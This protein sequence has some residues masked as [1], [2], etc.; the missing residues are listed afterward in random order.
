MIDEIKSR[1]RKA[2]TRW[3]C[4]HYKDRSALKRLAQLASIS[5]SLLQEPAKPEQNVD[6]LLEAVL[7]RGHERELL[8]AIWTRTR[9][10][11]AQRDELLVIAEGFGINDLASTPLSRELDEFEPL[12][13]AQEAAWTRREALRG[14]YQVP[15]SQLYVD[16]S[17]A[18][19]GLHGR[20][21]LSTWLAGGIPGPRRLVV[22]G[23]VGSGKT[24]LLHVTAARMAA[25]ARCEDTAP[26]PLLLDA[27]DLLRAADL[28][29]AATRAWPQA[30]ESV[31][32]LLSDRFTPLVLLIDRLDEAADPELD[33]RIVRMC[34]EHDARL[35][36]LIVTTRPSYRPAL[37]ES[38]ALPLPR[39]T[40]P[41]V[42]RFLDSLPSPVAQI[43]RRLFG[44]RA[45][46]RE[47]L[48]NPLSATILAV[49]GAEEVENL[50]HPVHMFRALI[51]QLFQRWA[52]HRQHRPKW[53]TCA[54][55]LRR[56]ARE[57][58]EGERSGIERA[59][60]RQL[61]REEHPDDSEEFIDDLEL[62]L[63]ILI[64]RGDGYEFLF[65]SL[66]EH[67]AGSQIAEDGIP[68]IL[69]AAHEPWAQESVRHAAGCLRDAEARTEL[70]SS[71][72]MN[73]GA[74]TPG[75]YDNHLR[76]VLAAIDIAT[77]APDIDP[78]V[79]DR[80]TQA[81]FRRLA[82]EYSNWVGDE[83]ARRVPRMLQTDGRVAE[84]LTARCL[85]LL[86]PPDAGVDLPDDRATL[87]KLLHHHNPRVCRAVIRKLYS[88][89]E[90]TDV[91]SDLL[92]LIHDKRG[93][94]F[95]RSVGFEAALALRRVPRTHLD[96]QL[97]EKLVAMLDDQTSGK[98]F[99]HCVLALLPG[100]APVDKLADDLA[101]CIHHSLDTSEPIED[102]LA[103]PGG[104]E[105]LE[106]HF[107][108][109]RAKQDENIAQS[110]RLATPLPQTL[111]PSLI[112]RMRAA[113]AL[114]SRLH[115]L[116]E[117]VLVHVLDDEENVHALT[118]CFDK[119]DASL[120]AKILERKAR[121]S[122]SLCPGCRKALS[123]AA[124]L[125]GDI[126]DLLVHWWD[127]ASKQR[128]DKQ[129][130]RSYFPGEM[131]EPLVLDDSDAARVYSEWL[132]HLVHTKFIN[133]PCDVW[134]HAP[135]RCSQ[136]V[137]TVR[138]QIFDER[139]KPRERALRLLVKGWQGDPITWNRLTDH[140]TCAFAG[141][142]HV[143]A[144]H[145]PPWPV[146]GDRSPMDRTDGLLTALA[147]IDVVP[148]PRFLAAFIH[149]CRLQ[150]HRAL[151]A[152]SYKNSYTDI[153]PPQLFPVLRHL[154]LV[155][156]LRG[157]LLALAGVDRPP[158]REI[159]LHAAVLVSRDLGPGD[160]SRLSRLWAEHHRNTAQAEHLP[161]AE[162][163]HLMSLDIQAWRDALVAHASQ[164]ADTPRYP[165][166]VLGILQGI[167]V[168]LVRDV[169]PLWLKATQN[170]RLPWVE[171]AFA[172]TYHTRIDDKLREQAFAIRR[173]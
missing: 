37:G 157:E 129:A 162:L 76:P 15:L 41:D 27:I 98:P 122:W 52:K 77:D 149:G 61:L 78:V 103:Y 53:A 30:R 160:Q 19:P 156:H 33:A 128:P 32:A 130:A 125:R 12:L 64:P 10:A 168:A 120:H 146:N 25:R 155:D 62:G 135:F 133:I 86:L 60:L 100:E 97:K 66:A 89:L 57:M 147:M 141:D 116:D 55:H 90:H 118:H 48:A 26:I 88:S 127:V 49:L 171:R 93:R 95:D 81:T 108:G 68:A 96:P 72:L 84:Q 134:S 83:V 14:G 22:F 16:P 35:T 115:L 144:I 18:I 63:G 67:L 39:W 170:W 85:A 2:L 44:E 169:L 51:G 152:S 9:R 140:V 102:L 166:L 7:N 75:V 150:I 173:L 23:E 79:A 165:H 47:L 139:G 112:A 167:P 121:T 109:W 5:T 70:L 148:P 138:D 154:D 46:V 145:A 117:A 13:A 163:S 159:G 43:L 38:T 69:N 82:E 73:E 164:L 6:D 91:Q 104:A 65:R 87:R 92:Q 99:A 50:H 131:L 71:L 45:M 143:C 24:E 106:R 11:P 151:I 1:A 142:A 113:E 136:V 172:E 137:D 94:G 36:A 21:P 17:L 74:D 59:A 101:L 42:R 20:Y 123:S 126:R 31:E 161:A 80:L 8:Q 3:L 124:E 58:V 29:E 158:T 56:W 132:V 4:Q 110:N 28:R 107:P 40:E 153:V 114:S 105:A 119:L 54:P 111:A 34:D